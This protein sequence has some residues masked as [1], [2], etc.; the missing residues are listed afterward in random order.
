MC[1]I[2]TSHHGHRGKLFVSDVSLSTVWLLYHSWCSGETC[3]FNHQGPRR[4]VGLYQLTQYNISEDLD[5]CHLWCDNVKNYV[6]YDYFTQS[7]FV[8]IRTLGNYAF[9]VSMEHAFYLAWIPQEWC[10]DLSMWTVCYDQE[11]LAFYSLWQVREQSLSNRPQWFAPRVFPGSH[12]FTGEW[13]SAALVIHCLKKI[14]KFGLS[15]L[16]F[17]MQDILIMKCDAHRWWPLASLYSC[18]LNSGLL[19][20]L[21][22][23]NSKGNG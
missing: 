13:H 19:H 21:L 16:M 3:C 20:I 9:L 14:S 22:S 1:S 18:Y 15:T 8:W 2:I 4:M 10:S 12:S 6:I 23:I 7:T 17:Q 5:V 11:L